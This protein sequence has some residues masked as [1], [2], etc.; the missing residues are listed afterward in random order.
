MTSGGIGKK[1]DSIKEINPKY[2]GACR[3]AEHL[4]VN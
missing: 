1:D 3:C 4:I 2:Q